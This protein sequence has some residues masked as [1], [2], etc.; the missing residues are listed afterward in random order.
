MYSGNEHNIVK[1]FYSNKKKKKKRGRGEQFGILRKKW[2]LIS[3]D[4]VSRFWTYTFLMLGV[5]FSFLESTM[6]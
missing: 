5:E 3:E 6:V 4:L 2:S 1:H